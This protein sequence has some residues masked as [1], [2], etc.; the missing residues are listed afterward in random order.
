MKNEQ[1][2]EK[3]IDRIRK[4]LE[5]QA[6]KYQNLF[7]TILDIAISGLDLT[8]LEKL[9]YINVKNEMEEMIEYK[10]IN[11]KKNTLKFFRKYLKSKSKIVYWIDLLDLLKKEAK[12][13]RLK[14]KESILRNDHI[15][16]LDKMDSGDDIYRNNNVTIR[17]HSC[18]HI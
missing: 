1:E 17:I 4:E 15:N 10:P 14:C 13:Y 11:F 8:E 3:E 5:N 6:E 9:A 7:K 12:D 18:C 16:D 2:P